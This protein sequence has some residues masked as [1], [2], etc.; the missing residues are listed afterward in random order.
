MSDSGSK[1]GFS[2]YKSGSS[3]A[4]TDRPKKQRSVDVGKLRLLP[5]V[6][7][8]AI[9]VG[10]LL[11]STTLSSK[12]EVSLVKGQEFYYHDADYYADAAQQVLSENLA[13]KTKFTINT[14]EAESKLVEKFPEVRAAVLRLPVLG[15]KP[16]LVLDIRPPSA[17]LSTNSRTFIL[18]DN[19]RA[20]SD[21]KGIDNKFIKDLPVIVD[22][23][24]IE[25]NLGDPV[26]TTDTIYFI[27]NLK[28]Q[29][30]AK[31]LKVNQ[32]VLPAS[33]SQVD[34]YIDGLSYF[35]KTD[36]AGDPRMQIGSFLSVKQDLE[37]RGETPSE[38]IDVRVEEKAF[39]K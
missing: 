9:I 36:A 35:V 30:D 26:V 29:L 23:S 13:Y 32:Y 1:A 33:A 5:S 24:G 22:Q 11:F 21:I 6:A 8:L 10:S 14:D 27:K 15:R 16:T 3:K 17:L 28:L 19:G 37:G 38:Y 39:Y 25:V 4:P 31:G 20:I 12:P 2:Y 34:I 18:D 7:A